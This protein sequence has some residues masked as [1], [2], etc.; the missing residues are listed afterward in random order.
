M[1]EVLLRMDSASG[2]FIAVY[3]WSDDLLSVV[4]LRMK[5]R[6]S[7]SLECCSKFLADEKWK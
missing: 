5:F 1:D 2:Y 6:R 3:C 7:E 4:L